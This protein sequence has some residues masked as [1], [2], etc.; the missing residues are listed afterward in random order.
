MDIGKINSRG[1]KHTV[2]RI[3]I[4]VNMEE[5]N[6]HSMSNGQVLRLERGWNNLNRREVSPVNAVVVS[7][8]GIKKGAQI[9]IHHNSVHETYRL[10]N[11]GE[12]SGQKI[13]DRIEYYSIPETQAYFWLDGEEWKPMRGYA[14]GLQVYEPY[15]GILLGIAPKLIKDVLYITSG[16]L[17]GKIC[18][19]VR[20]ANYCVVFQDI[21][22]RERQLIRCRH[23]DDEDNDIEEIIAIH[24]QY[25]NDVNKGKL[26]LGYSPSDAKPL[27][28]LVHA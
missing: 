20:A 7:G 10:T 12:L 3:V 24:D 11:H 19:T 25:T 23:W 1:L 15:K 27:K 22:N 17:K 18:I 2:G 13:A 9:I 4:R 16:E 5:K 26:H 21:D 14:T 6:Y 8:E 28:E